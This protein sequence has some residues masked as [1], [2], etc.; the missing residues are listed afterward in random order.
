[1]VKFGGPLSDP[2]M[3]GRAA[4]PRIH[5]LIAAKVESR[6][7]IGTFSDA[8]LLAFPWHYLL[9]KSPFMKSVS[10]QP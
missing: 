4:L 7:A 10:V 1:M 8:V 9:N 3:R 5:L 6:V 2:C